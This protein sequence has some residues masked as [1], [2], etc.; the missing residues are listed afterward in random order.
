MIARLFFPGK[1]KSAW[2]GFM[3]QQNAFMNQN[4]FN[5]YEIEKSIDIKDANAFVHKYVLLF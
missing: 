4:D 2:G 3:V 1:K 5:Q